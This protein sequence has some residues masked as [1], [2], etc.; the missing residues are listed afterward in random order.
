MH[1]LRANG[2]P[3]NEMVIPRRADRA[4]GRCRA[5]AA[6]LG[7]GYAPAVFNS[8]RVR[9][10]EPR[11]TRSVNRAPHEQVVKAPKKSSLLVDARLPTRANKVAS[12]RH[13][14]PPV[15]K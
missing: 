11:R 14:T 12:S 13:T 1:L 5:S 2:L 7:G 4:P 3:C 8:H 9:P 10:A 6:L 15:A